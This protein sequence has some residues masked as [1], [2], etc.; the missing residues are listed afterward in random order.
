VVTVELQTRQDRAKADA[1]K[2]SNSTPGK[3]RGDFKMKLSTLCAALLIAA[4]VNVAGAGLFKH[5]H[6]DCCAPAA[7]CCNAAPNCAAP[8]GPTC[9]APACAPACAAPA[10]APACAAPACAPACAAPACAPS[11]EAPCAPADCCAPVTHCKRKCKL[12][13]W[14]KGLKKKHGCHKCDDVCA[15]ADACGPS[16]GAPCGPTCGAPACAPACA[17]PCGA[18]K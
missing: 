5:K 14:F 17:A 4:S 15:P 6:N 1:E 9:G 13:G 11:C 16:C 7:T 8:C 12:A 2:L 10:C 18:C 3:S